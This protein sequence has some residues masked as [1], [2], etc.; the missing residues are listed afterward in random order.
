MP[1]NPVASTSALLTYYS[2]DL[3]EYTVDQVV[4]DWLS[5][6]PAKWVI[7]AVVESIYQGRY[8]IASVNNILVKWYLQGQPQHH[9]DIEFADLVCGKLFKRIS[10]ESEAMMS[11]LDYSPTLTFDHPNPVKLTP[12]IQPVEPVEPAEESVRVATR[13]SPQDK[14]P[15]Q[16]IGRWL[17]LVTKL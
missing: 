4:E 12:E 13:L 6:Y 9:F 8:K 7:A 17:K 10:A 14:V 1:R 5:E 2:F 16:G 15:N 3:G 11:G